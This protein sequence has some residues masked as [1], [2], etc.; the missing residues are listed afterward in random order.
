[1]EHRLDVAEEEIRF[2]EKFLQELWRM[3]RIIIGLIQ[4]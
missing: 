2:L 1:M 4:K 3:V